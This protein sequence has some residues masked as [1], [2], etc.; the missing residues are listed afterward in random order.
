MCRPSDSDSGVR[1]RLWQRQ[2]GTDHAVAESRPGA[3]ARS[4]TCPRSG[5]RTGACTR[6]R[7]VAAAGAAS[8]LVVHNFS[9]ESAVAAGGDRNR[10]AYDG[11]AERGHHHRS[12]NV[13]SRYGASSVEQL[14]S[15]VAA[16]DIDLTDAEQQ[17]L[18]AAAERFQPATGAAI[19]PQLVR[20]RLGR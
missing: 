2:S 20:A 7:A 1:R 18:R 16:A 13:R 19:V 14:E 12:V 15:N 6:A 17:A 10:H 11:S 9:S 4:G 5:A 8:A 3:R